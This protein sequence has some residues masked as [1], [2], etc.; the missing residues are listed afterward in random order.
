MTDSNIQIAA[1]VATATPPAQSSV[2][3]ATAAPV[4][5][6][7]ETSLA[8]IAKTSESRQGLVCKNLLEGETKRQAEAD[9]EKVYREMLADTQVL[10]L[11]GTDALKDVNALVERLLKE[12]EP[13]QI[14]E[15]Q[16]LMK[17]LNITMLNIKKKYDMS[18]PKVR[19]DY[20]NWTKGVNK[21]KGFFRRGRTFIEVLRSDFTDIEKQLDRVS[22]ELA[23]R[24]ADMSRN[25][26]FLDTIYEE[27]EKE[28]AK[29]IYVIAVMELIVEVAAKDADAI[30]VG[31][32]SV[33]D[34][35]QEERQK[36]ADLITNMNAKIGEYKGRLFIAWATAPQ[37]RMMRNLDVGMSG[38]LNEM[39]NV[40]VPTMKQLLLQWRMMVQTED[41][42]KM[43]EAV[44]ATANQ[45]TQEFFKA[46]AEAM[47]AIER[48]IQTPT[49][50]PETLSVVA[51]SLA[52]AAAGVLAEYQEGER[53]RNELDVAMVAAQQQL[54]LTHREIDEVVI[55]RVIE[56]ATTPP[57][58]TTSVPATPALT[59]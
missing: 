10:M 56:A 53:K 22:A 9:A 21:V 32:S 48:A 20:E 40:T 13:T 54:A 27:N 51:D 29:L 44:Q 42:G 1:P 19:K 55:D 7:A 31:D 50:T 49:F 12:V 15:L 36:R 8:V 11:F 18:D 6:P 33:G 24:Q 59:A 39:V 57:Q 41:A 2:L 45:W 4:E 17:D 52:Q 47:P 25:V 14:P 23:G 46:G 34:R 26:A 58:I 30:Q 43:S 37:T 28:I 38:K 35:G 5:G 3:E 16:G